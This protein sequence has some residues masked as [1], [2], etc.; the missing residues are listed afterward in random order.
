MSIRTQ[1]NPIQWP[2]GLSQTARSNSAAALD[3]SPTRACHASQGAPLHAKPRLYRIR[4]NN[5]AVDTSFDTSH[6]F[7]VAH[8]L[9]RTRRT[10]QPGTAG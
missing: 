7:A 6:A 5:Y 9:P 3:E 4:S 8:D 2:K 10:R 1:S